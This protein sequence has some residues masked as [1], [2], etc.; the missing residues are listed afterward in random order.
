[1]N[2]VQGSMLATTAV[3]LGMTG[4][5]LLTAVVP[6]RATGNLMTAT[7]KMFVV[8]AAQGGIAEVMTSRLA[9]SH[10]SNKNVLMVA[11]RMIKEHGVANA[12]LKQTTM[13]IH[14][15]APS[16]TDPMHMAAY[17][18]LSRL[19]G[20]AFDKAYMSGQVKDHDAT[21]ALFKTEIEK[22]QESPIR[23]FATKYLPTIQDHTIM[24]HNVAANL[25]ADP[26]AHKNMKM[27]M[28]M[29]GM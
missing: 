29:K 18:K 24:I 10:S 20:A 12:D 5:A 16:H 9:L 22:G 21:V 1:M 4:A 27:N 23:G 28:H 7:D 8:K 15:M 3:L 13:K 6:A 25:E 19:H 11:R 17:A 14:V 2:K 26:S